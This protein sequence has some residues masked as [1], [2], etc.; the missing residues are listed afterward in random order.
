ML[1][2]LTSVLTA[3]GVSGWLLVVVFAVCLIDG[4]FPPVPSETTVVAGLTLAFAAHASPWMIAG[5]L[6]AAAAGA[7]SGDSI[8]FAIG[9]RV[10]TDRW[11]WMRRPR[12]ARALTWARGQVDRRPAALILGARYI[13]IGR[14]AVNVTAGASG[15]AYRRFL[16]I[17]L[18]AALAWAGMCWLLSSV[19]SAWLGDTPLVATLVAV[20]ASI[21]LGIVVD[22]VSR[23]I[24]RV[25][26][27]RRASSLE[28]AV[29]GR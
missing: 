19:V 29:A 14:V 11:R 9:R 23:V 16:P 5:V 18:L 15:M 1:V 27:R 12:V 26:E 28:N 20:A 7:A 2:D 10:G 4:F 3:V 17:S 25:R 6:A 22:L 8:A 21:V 13:P 24:S